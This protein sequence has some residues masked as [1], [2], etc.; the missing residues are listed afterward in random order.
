MK[1]ITD[2]LADLSRINVDVIVDVDRSVILENYMMPALIKRPHR[3][4]VVLKIGNA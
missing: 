3:N 2:R 1:E 4:K